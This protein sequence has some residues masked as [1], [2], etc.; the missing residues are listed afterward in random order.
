MPMIDPLEAAIAL[1][2]EAIPT[3]LIRQEQ[4]AV[5][6]AQNTAGKAGVIVV[7]VA[8]LDRHL[9]APLITVRLSMRCYKLPT[10]ADG[11]GS[12][13]IAKL[14]EPVG[15]YESGVARPPRVVAGRFY[16][17]YFHPQPPASP[18]QEPD[19]DLWA[20]IV[21]AECALNAREIA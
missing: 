18:L 21:I 10:D 2:G 11:S 5:P 19:S 17:R 13:D 20:S 8:P 6:I 14:I 4:A 12:A 9:T 3:C 1:L 15:F 7:S 16:V